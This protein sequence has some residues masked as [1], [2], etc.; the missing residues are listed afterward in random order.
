MF[1]NDIFS[2]RNTMEIFYQ[3]LQCLTVIKNVRVHFIHFRK[4][5]KEFPQKKL[6]QMVVLTFYEG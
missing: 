5:W 2:S 3:V 1:K 4:L 6:I